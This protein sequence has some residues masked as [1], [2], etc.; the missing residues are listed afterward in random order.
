MDEI[1]KMDVNDTG[2][3]VQ[4]LDICGNHRNNKKMQ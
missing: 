4:L 3:G 2:E 1:M